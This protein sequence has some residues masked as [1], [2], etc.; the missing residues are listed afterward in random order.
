MGS[1]R[2]RETKGSLSLWGLAGCEAKLLGWA[3]G[4][5]HKPLGTL[6][7]GERAGQA[8]GSHI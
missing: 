3:G 5:L 2:V 7:C 8:P 1:L 4:R 6:D